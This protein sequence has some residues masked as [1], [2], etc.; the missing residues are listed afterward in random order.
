MVIITASYTA[1]LVANLTV[2]KISPP[3]TDLAGMAAQN[4]YI[5]G[6]LGKSFWEQSFTVRGDGNGVGG[7]RLWTESQIQITPTCLSFSLS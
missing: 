2:V 4:K 5:F 6:T 7:M 1:N 3:F